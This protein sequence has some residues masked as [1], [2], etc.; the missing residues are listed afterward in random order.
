MHCRLRRPPPAVRRLEASYPWQISRNI[1][2][3]KKISVRYPSQSARQ[4]YGK[5]ITPQQLRLIDQIR[6]G[7]RAETLCRTRADTT[8]IDVDM[9]RSD[10][11]G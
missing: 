7:L 5:K 4:R 8:N 2:T 3:A 10:H 9:A 1:L 6:R 11:V